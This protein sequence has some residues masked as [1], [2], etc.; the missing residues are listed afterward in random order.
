MWGRRCE[1]INIM[2]SNENGVM[3]QISQDYFL[4]KKYL[5]MT[6][7]ILRIKQLL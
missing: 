3:L 6:L 7:H 5:E 4:T 2:H 1:I